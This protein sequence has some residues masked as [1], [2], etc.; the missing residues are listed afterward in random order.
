MTAKDDAAGGAD[1]ER[2]FEELVEELETVTE[3]LAGGQIGI[4]QAADLYERA[5]LLHRLARARLDAVQARVDKLA[6]DPAGAEDGSD[7]SR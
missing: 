2:S 1:D 7:A 6:G 4:E 3:Q 5:E